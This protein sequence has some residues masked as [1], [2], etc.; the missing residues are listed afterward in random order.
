MAR[1]TMLLYN[2]AYA[3]HGR[4]FSDDADVEELRQR[5]AHCSLSPLKGI[6]EAAMNVES[7]LKDR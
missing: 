5:A 6:D 1:S 3:R 4:E 2:G 7:Y